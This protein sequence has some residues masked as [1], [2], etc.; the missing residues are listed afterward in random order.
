M[1]YR[2]LE[3]AQGLIALIGGTLSQPMAE[4]AQ[5]GWLNPKYVDGQDATCC[6]AQLDEA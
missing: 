3:K 4:H 2:C 1:F 6:V 5:Y